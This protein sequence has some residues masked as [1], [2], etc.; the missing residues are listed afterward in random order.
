MRAAEW[1]A[2][3]NKI[4]IPLVPNSDSVRPHLEL[5]NFLGYLQKHYQLH[6]HASPIGFGKHRGLC[7]PALYTQAALPLYIAHSVTRTMPADDSSKSDESHFE[8]C[9][10]YYLE[11]C[12][13]EA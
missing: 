8:G 13:V 4:I 1:A 7:L 2:V 11:S 6:N 5:A 3:K 9:G 10:L 12:D